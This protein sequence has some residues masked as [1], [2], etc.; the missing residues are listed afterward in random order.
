[1][2]PTYTRSM[3][4]GVVNVKGLPR[5][6]KPMREIRRRS[7]ARRAP[8]GEAFR[9]DR[10]GGCARPRRRQLRAARRSRRL[11]GSEVVASNDR[12][13]PETKVVEDERFTER[14][15][16]FAHGWERVEEDRPREDDDQQD[17]DVAKE[18]DVDGGNL[19]QQPVGRQASDT[20]Q[21][22]ENDR[23]RDADDD[24]EER[25]LDAL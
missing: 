14:E 25:V 4:S 20:D 3:I 15:P 23:E 21:C 24:D 6:T 8:D 17:G 19:R 1:M 11:E 7:R 13:E 10:T 9:S 5:A 2:P 16:R 22:A 12:R 18:L